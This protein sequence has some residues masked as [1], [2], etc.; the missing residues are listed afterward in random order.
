MKI[1]LAVTLLHLL[2]I[3]PLLY[4]ENTPPITPAKQITVRTIQPKI[5][6]AKEEVRAPA[7]VAVLEKPALKPEQPKKKEVVKKEHVKTKKINS[8][9]AP[10][11]KDAL[12]ALLEDSLHSL[13]KA[14]LAKSAP[15]KAKKIG[16]LKSELPA[17]IPYEELLTS[18]LQNHM[19]FPEKG[20]VKVKIS[21]GPEGKI[22][23]LEIVKASSKINEKYVVETLP[24]L[25]LPTP[26]IKTAN[27]HTLFVTLTSN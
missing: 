8:P 3:F 2:L 1:F 12:L 11:S 16:P 19:R 9:S 25:L 22:A 27:L 26:P 4:L 13:E 21:V 5:E 14:P 24:T 18:F 20:D 17:E 23:L 7:A 15:T 6:I 10:Q